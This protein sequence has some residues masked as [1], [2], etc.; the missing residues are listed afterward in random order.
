MSKKEKE[1]NK[2]S[3]NNK[4]V[5]YNNKPIDTLFRLLNGIKDGSIAAF[6]GLK[7]LFGANQKEVVGT[8]W[9][10]KNYRGVDILSLINNECMDPE[11][12]LEATKKD[13]EKGIEMAPEKLENLIEKMVD[14]TNKENSEVSDEHFEVHIN[15]PKKRAPKKTNKRT[16]SLTDIQKGVE[17]N[18]KDQEQD[19]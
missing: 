7:G 11:M 3:E 19:K 8:N 16:I 10:G 18:Q 15:E 6:E 5:P 4:L 12:W 2:K 13:L 14:S 17:E 9:F 1:T